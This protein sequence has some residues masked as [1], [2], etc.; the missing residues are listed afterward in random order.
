[1]VARGRRYTQHDSRA[2]SVYCQNRA[3]NPLSNT[4]GLL[5]INQLILFLIAYL[6]AL[7]DLPSPRS[8]SF[9][10][11]NV[12]LRLLDQSELHH[13]VTGVPQF[14][15]LAFEDDLSLYLNSESNANRL[16][17]KVHL[18]ER[19]S[20]NPSHA[21]VRPHSG[22]RGRAGYYTMRSADQRPARPCNS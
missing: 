8:C 21:P 19:W 18:F 11:I 1:M 22:G 20:E 14:S 9:F 15:H 12:L 6:I 16:Q 13:G 10:F 5:L 4:R 7:R 17:E 2:R 3:I